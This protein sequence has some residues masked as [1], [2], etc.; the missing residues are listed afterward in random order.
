LEAGVDR[1]STGY[2]D[3]IADSLY[4]SVLADILDGLGYRN[5]VMRP[6]V[7]PLYLGARVAG[8]AATMLVVNVTDVPE[9][10]YRLL[11]ELLDSM[12]VGEVAVAGVQG[13]ARAAMWGELLS[14]HT[15]A[16]GGRGAVLDGLCRDRRRIT[17]MR[18]PVFAT[19]CSPADS[20]G[21]LDV[22]S[23][24]G[25]IPVGGV[26]VAD[27]DLVVADDDGCVVVPSAVEDHAVTQAL[28]KVSAENTVR[29][30]LRQG[31]SIRT[32]FQDHRV[33]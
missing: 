6:E 14:T 25:T 24:R 23:I 26:T 33:L 11:M 16:H 13:T 4:S 18:F 17:E 7:R 31:A 27:G 12:K 3:R 15:R 2:L 22:I 28:V 21:R 5:Q 10:P 8:R 19:G 20:K 30:V 1:Y 9:Q 29:E 32:A